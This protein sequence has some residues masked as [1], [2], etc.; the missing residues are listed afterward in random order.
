[1]SIEELNK[2]QKELKLLQSELSKLQI[3]YRDLEGY[4]LYLKT[5]K[6]SRG[7]TDY[8]NGVYEKKKKE[9]ELLSSELEY[10]KEK[11]QRLTLIA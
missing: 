4:V 8:E 11:K 1:M 3:K 2:L 9:L 5:K 7:L 10:T 6:L